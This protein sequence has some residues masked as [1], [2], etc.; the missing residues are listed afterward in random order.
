MEWKQRLQGLQV[1]QSARGLPPEAQLWVAA[2]LAQ[3]VVDAN[4]KVQQQVGR[5]DKTQIS[6]PATQPRLPR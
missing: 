4:L 6:W 2:R 5:A 1:L 3:H